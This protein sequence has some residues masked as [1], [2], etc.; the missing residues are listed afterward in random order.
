VIA[1]HLGAVDRVVRLMEREARLLGPDSPLEMAVV[2]DDVRAEAERFLADI[3]QAV[4]GSRD[5]HEQTLAA[6]DAEIARLEA[7]L[8]LPHDG[9]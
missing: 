7:L 2:T 3:D 4:N 5:E 8:D 9:G 1:G 6:R